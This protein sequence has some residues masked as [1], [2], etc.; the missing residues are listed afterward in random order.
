VIREL[1]LVLSGANPGA[2][3]DNVR[4]AHSDG[5]YDDL[6][7]EAVIYTGLTLEHAD[8]TPA[9]DDEDEDEDDDEFE[10]ADDDGEL[11]V[12]D[13]YDAMTE[14]EQNVVQY[15]IGAAV[16]QA[17]KKST[18]TSAAHS[19]TDAGTLSH[20]EG[21]DD[22]GRNVFE[23]H[24]SGSNSVTGSTLSHEDVR[25]IVA[26]AVR[27]GSLKEAVDRYALKHGIDNIDTLFPDAKNIT[28]TP[29]FN[30][31]RTEWVASVLNGT[32]H[33]PFSRIKTISAD[34]TQEEARARGYIKGNYKIEEWFG[35]SKRTTT[36]TT[37]YKKQQL[38]RDDVLDITDFDVVA[39]LKAEMRLMLEEEIATAILIGDGRSV[40]D[41]SKIKDPLGAA[42]GQGIRS[43][44]NE[45]E[46]YKTELNVS[47]DPTDP[48]SNYEKVVDAVI[49]GMEFYKGN[50]TPVFYTTIRHLNMFLKAKDNNGQRYYKNKSE[51]AEALGVSAVVTVETM[52][53]VPDLIGIIVNLD[54][55]AVGTDRG[56]EI[57]MFDD[58]DIDYNRQKYLM[59]TRMSG[60]L[61]K[62]KSALVLRMK[63]A[64]DTML[65]DPA[66]PDY[67]STTG[68]VTI[69]TVPNVTYKNSDSGATLAAGPQPALTPGQT[70]NVEAE[71]ATGFYFA[72]D[73]G[74][75][76]NFF[77]RA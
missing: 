74:A 23:T 46:L 44:L 28:E 71:P 20:Q 59:E 41:E 60:A 64:D 25:G 61:T 6:E 22:M 42:D 76:W 16:E 15:L 18:S 52:Q 37:I 56:G 43:I 72:T 62:I 4:L 5:S 24:G 69:P 9:G 33:V 26:D 8:T 17:T 51:V 35:V 10:H 2:L 3:I 39:W 49:D 27:N 45:H 55:Y 21:N 67:N 53:R 7:D 36:P 32:R 12:Q 1:S 54:D 13:V 34:I 75:F 57:N 48:N 11:T 40:V 30:K 63:S 65:A 19:N 50:G 70:L 73:E 47:V 68:V 77:R 14:E 38:D 29:E 66:K 31:R 58:F